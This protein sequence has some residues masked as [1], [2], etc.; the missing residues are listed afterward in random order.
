MIPRPPRTRVFAGWVL[1]AVAATLGAC[2]SSPSDGYAFSSA[3][4]QDIRTVA[5]PMFENSTFAH[6]LEAQLADALVKEL[7][8]STPWRVAPREQ[9]QT[10][11]A[12]TITGADLRTLSRQSESGLVQELAVDLAVSFEWKENRTGTV[13]VAR[14]NFRA[15]EPFTPGFG[16]GERLELGRRSAIDQMARDIVAELRSSW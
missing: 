13:L 16:A 8:R 14:R 5:V 4:R 1:G 9:A 10:T 6:G 11:L 2:A 12:G 7:H 3:Y 15:A